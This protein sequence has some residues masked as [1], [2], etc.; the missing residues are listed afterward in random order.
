MKIKKNNLSLTI[1]KVKFSKI[2]QNSIKSLNL[3]EIILCLYDPF[4]CTV[5]RVTP[6]KPQSPFP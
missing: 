6:R 3:N 4:H 1:F 2:V 5:R